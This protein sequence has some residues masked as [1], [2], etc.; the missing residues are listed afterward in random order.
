MMKRIGLC[1]VLVILLA[2]SIA[3]AQEDHEMDMLKPKQ[4][5]NEMEMLKPKKEEVKTEFPLGYP[6]TSWGEITQTPIGHDETG[7]KIDGY[8]EQGV[9]WFKVFNTDWKFNTFVALRGTAA[10]HQIDYFNNKIGPWAGFKFKKTFDFGNDNSGSLYL[11]VRWEYYHYLD[12]GPPE[13]I[14]HHLFFTS[15]RDDN[16]LTFFLQWS[17]G[18]DWKKKSNQDNKEK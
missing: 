5:Y 9:D 18:G 10:T 11:G 8:I 12:S 4:E 1:F 3:F 14:D 2:C 15:I 16:R 13:K 7:F 6:F 17:F